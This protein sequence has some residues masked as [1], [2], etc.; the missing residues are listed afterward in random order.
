M[1]IS[2]RIPASLASRAEALLPLLQNRWAVALVGKMFYR[3]DVLRYALIRGLDI[4][5]KELES[6][7][8]AKAAEE[9]E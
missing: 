5:E 9:D 1:Q 7:E 6:I 2:L 3:S 8:A 4:I